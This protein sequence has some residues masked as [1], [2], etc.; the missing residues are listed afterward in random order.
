MTDKQPAPDGILRLINGYWATGVLGAAAGHSLF[1]HLEDGADTAAR[2]AGRAGISERGAQT[3]LDGLVSIGLAELRDGAYRNTAEAS[4]FLVEGRPADL[5]GLARL[6]LKHMGNLVSL[7]EVVRVGGPVADAA[8]EVADNP[9]WG[10]VV[11]AIAAQSVPAA[12]VAA[13]VLRLADAGEISILDVGGGSGIY[14][15]VW[16][17]RNPAA[18]STQLDW[19]PIN[20]IARRLVAE[21]GVA[22]RFSCVDGDFHTTDFGTA[23]HDVALYSHIAHQEGPRENVAVFTRLRKALKPGGALVVCDY[24]VED[25]RSGPAFP[26]LFAS[27]MLLKSKQ[28]GTWRRSDYHAWLTEAGFEDISFHSAPPA[29][30][31]IARQ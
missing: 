23:A 28:G 24:V 21:R 27:E 13:D 1:T 3:L 6:K 16:L 17:R 9:H 4:A 19:A 18:R 10:E 14:S 15:A 29:T 26:L 25:D 31:V 12:E 8:V 30:L 5:S 11:P 7:P 20:A 2:L 22:D